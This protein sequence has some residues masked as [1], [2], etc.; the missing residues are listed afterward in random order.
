VVLLID[1]SCSIH[2]GVLATS[3]TLL[4]VYWLPTI[5]AALELERGHT[6]RAIKLLDE[7]SAHDLADAG[8]G[9]VGA[10]YPVYVRGLVYLRMG[11]SGQAEEQ[12][13]NIL[14]HGGLVL[15]FPLG[16]WAH[17]QLARARK[18]G[19]D[20]RGENRLP[21]FSRIVE[22]RRPRRSHPEASQG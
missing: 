1:G 20:T 17:L 15:N 21:R 6:Q 19:G 3:D 14:D 13:Q 10:M 5:R 7:A 4:Q 8:P 11:Q 22:G 2:I 12:F 18:L 16:A 9:Q